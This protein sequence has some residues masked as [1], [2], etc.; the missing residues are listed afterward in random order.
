MISI[1]NKL[2]IPS[3]AAPPSPPAEEFPTSFKITAYL[4]EN[5]PSVGHEFNLVRIVEE[6]GPPRIA[7]IEQ[8]IQ[9][10]ETR[11]ASLSKEKGQIARL[12]AALADPE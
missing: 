4:P 10:L 1:K 11:I 8:E 9:K 3:V 12:V 5:P 7:A 6:H 2:R